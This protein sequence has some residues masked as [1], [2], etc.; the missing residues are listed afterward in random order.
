[1][2]SRLSLSAP[3]RATSAGTLCMTIG[4]TAIWSS[5]VSAAI[6]APLAVVTAN[7]EVEAAVSTAH[8]PGVLRADDH[9]RGA[10]VE[11]EAR[12]HIIDL[13]RDDEFAAEALVDDDF[14]A[15]A[16]DGL[17]RIEL[18]DDAIGEIGE[19][20]AIGVEAG[21]S[22]QQRRPGQCAA[23]RPADPRR[24]QPPGTAQ[25][26]PDDQRDAEGACAKRAWSKPRIGVSGGVR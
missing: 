12:R 21:Q 26:K 10:R 9:G 23:D 6:A 8:F 16:D 20:E 15:L 13:A 18:G 4:P 25:Q 22:D 3:G 1:M 24:P 11:Q 7:V 19:F 14:A 5:R 17:V 2:P